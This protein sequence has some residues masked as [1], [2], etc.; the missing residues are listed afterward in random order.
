MINTIKNAII[1]F[2]ETLEGIKNVSGYIDSEGKNGYPYICVVW[3]ANESEVIT[4]AQDRVRANYKIVL[5]QEKLE[6]FKTRAAAEITSDD[7][8]HKIEKVFRENN[9][10]GLSSVLRVLPVSSKKTYID[11]GTRIKVEVSLS[12]EFLQDVTL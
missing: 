3:E 6:Q 7:R 5:L 9:D 11:G 8:T 10:L 2:L 4:N 12:V 1:G